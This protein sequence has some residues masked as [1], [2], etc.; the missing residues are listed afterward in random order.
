[1]V[2]LPRSG[3]TLL[4]LMLDA[5]PQLAIP[6]ETHFVPDLIKAARQDD[7]TPESLHE[8]VTQ[9]RHWADFGL[10]PSELLERLR[11]IDPPNAG[12]AI[13]AFFSLYAE[14]QGK[15]RWGDKTPA[16]VM[17]MRRIQRALP[18]A[19]FIHLIRDGRD[20]ALSRADRAISVPP[21][22]KVAQ[23][24]KKRITEA[25]RDAPHLDRY[26]EVRYE[27]LV[28]D[29]EPALRRICEF[30]ALPWDEAMLDYHERAED[31][32]Q[33]MSGELRAEEGKTRQPEG[34]R[35]AVHAPTR[36]PPDPA[37]VARWRTQ[38]S[39]EDRAAFESIAGGLLAELG[40]EVS[41]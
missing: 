17:A 30:A 7:A 14:Q 23:R 10:D 16:Y 40:Y 15:P 36:E 6:A 1:V 21:V 19:G 39:D 2:G 34:Y 11:A 29:P 27:D 33:E 3:T 18:E 9:S 8:V 28:L 24:W 20:V 22:T 38:M 32:L 4:R 25:R 35:V 5:H 26:L 13:R 12:D 31:R 37:K 41:S